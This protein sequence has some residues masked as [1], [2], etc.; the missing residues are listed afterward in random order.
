MGLIIDEYLDPVTDKNRKLDLNR[1]G[2]INIVDLGL[3]IDD[4]DY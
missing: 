3:V 2:L 1:D 4:Y